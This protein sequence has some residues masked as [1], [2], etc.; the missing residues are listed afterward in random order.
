MEEA[1]ARASTQQAED[2]DIFVDRRLVTKLLVN[3]MGSPSSQQTEILEVMAR[4]LQFDD[5]TKKQVRSRLTFIHS[6]GGADCRLHRPLLVIYSNMNNQVGLTSTEGWTAYLP[7]GLGTATEERPSSRSP[8]A[9][10]AGKVTR[11]LLGRSGCRPLGTATQYLREVAN[12]A[13]RPPPPP[14]PKPPHARR[15][16]RRRPAPPGNRRQRRRRVADDALVW[17][18]RRTSPISG[19]TFC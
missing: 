4:I 19:R 3:Y 7:F 16:R 2:G 5:S 17:A 8:R 15:C 6:V 10:A 13:P 14:P 12:H 18:R 1:V 9:D 11:T